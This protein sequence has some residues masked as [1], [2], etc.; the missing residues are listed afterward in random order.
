[1]SSTARE[2]ILIPAEGSLALRCAFER[3]RPKTILPRAATAFVKVGSGYYSAFVDPV[4]LS[5]TRMPLLEALSE[6]KGFANDLA[7]VKL[8]QCSVHV[9]TKRIAGEEPTTE[10]EAV[11]KPL[12]G[13]NTIGSLAG[14]ATTLF[15]RVELPTT[16]G[17]A[18]SCPCSPLTLSAPL[19]LAPAHA[20]SFTFACRCWRWRRRHWRFSPRLCS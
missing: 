5:M 19:P 17:T 10:E 20:P 12:K 1:M 9:H 2:C 15:V 6:S 18:G 7:G 4:L 13:I 14:D 3:S 8:G 16:A 11:A